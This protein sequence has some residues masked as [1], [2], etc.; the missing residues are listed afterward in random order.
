MICNIGF[1]ATASDEA[2]E[3]NQKVEKTD[4][5][6]EVVKK[7]KKIHVYQNKSTYEGSYLCGKKSGMGK[8]TKRTKEFYN[9]N[10]QN[11]KKNGTGFQKYSNGDFYY[12]E[13]KNNKKNGQGIYFFSSTREYYFGEWCKGSLLSGSWI[14][15]RNTKYVGTF[16]RNL[17]KFKGC[18]IFADDS[19]IVVF[20]KQILGIS[21]IDQGIQDNLE[22]IWRA[23]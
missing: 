23:A 2:K 14:F 17:P 21:S 5:D 19:K 13:W 16:F 8:L 3:E 4:Q 7:N 9:G 11:G 6:S 10:F 20:Y 15:S 18:F 22:L 12:G 1:F